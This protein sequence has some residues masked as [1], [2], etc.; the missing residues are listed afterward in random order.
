MYAYIYYYSYMHILNSCTR[1]H[2]RFKTKHIRSL[3]QF[4]LDF[5]MHSMLLAFSKHLLFICRMRKNNFKSISYT[6]AYMHITSYMTKQSVSLPS[7]L[8]WSSVLQCVA[9]WCTVLQC[10]AMCCS[11]LQCVAV[12]CSVMQR[13]VLYHFHQGLLLLHHLCLCL[14]SAPVYVR[15]CVC[16]YVCVCAYM[17]VCVCV[18][19]CVCVW[20]HTIKLKPQITLI[21][22]CACVG[23]R[24]IFVTM[25]GAHFVAQVCAVTQ[26]IL[27][28]QNQCKELT[29]DYQKSSPLSNTFVADCLFFESF[30]K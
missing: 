2:T 8:A 12:C 1:M 7:G 16:V 29:G 13:A 22:Y 17:Y 30:K 14:R 27:E 20:V 4:H 23:A 26:F 21:H 25:P 24:P 11:V 19:V 10:D 3:Y 9:V 5:R 28:T 18:C 15:V 6:C